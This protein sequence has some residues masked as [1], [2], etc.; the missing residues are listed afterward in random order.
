MEFITMEPCTK[1]ITE[2]IVDFA[3]PT[4]STEEENRFSKKHCLGGELISFC[5]R[6]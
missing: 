1:P 3:E 6:G 4:F 2:S 5:F